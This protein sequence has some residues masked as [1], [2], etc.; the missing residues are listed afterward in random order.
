MPASF[1]SITG[2]SRDARFRRRCAS[3][4]W[5]SPRGDMWSGW[6]RAAGAKCWLLEPLMSICPPPRR[7]KGDEVKHETLLF[8]SNTRDHRT[9]MVQGQVLEDLVPDVRRNGV[10]RAPRKETL[11][12]SL[13]A[14]GRKVQNHITTARWERYMGE[15]Y[16]Q[17]KQ[18]HSRLSTPSQ[19]F[20]QYRGQ[21]SSQPRHSLSAHNSSYITATLIRRITRAFDTWM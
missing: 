9:N 12:I 18:S 21:Q 10:G 19:R 4:R 3:W 2:R 11:C 17:S 1:P 13:R 8:A 14:H 7:F 6:E 5:Q 20:V 15:Q 16:Q